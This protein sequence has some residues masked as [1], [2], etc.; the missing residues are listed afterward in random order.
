VKAGRG[1]GAL[2]ACAAVAV[3]V[4]L[5]AC[6]GPAADLFGVTRSGS[7]SGADIVIVPS[8]QG[9][10]TCDGHQKELPDPLLLE[11]E[12]FDF[13]YQAGKALRL[14]SGPHPV[15]T[16]SVTTENG[17]FSYS[18]DSPHLGPEL[19]KLAAWVFTVANSVCR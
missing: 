3:A 10:V 11:A 19:R 8:G 1:I 13:N 12:N 17:N 14:P 15:Y 2:L 16:Y 9:T 6:G 7:V 18:D 4:A 5:A